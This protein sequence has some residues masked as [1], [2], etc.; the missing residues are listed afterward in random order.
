MAMRRSGQSGKSGAKA[1]KAS[2]SVLAGNS[3]GKSRV[4]MVKVSRDARSKRHTVRELSVDIALEGD[5]EAIHTRGDNSRCL[6]TDTMKNTVYALGKD[7]SIDTIESFATH[8]ARHFVDRNPQVS[9]A[10]VRISEVRWDRVAVRGREHPHCFI[11]GS[12]ERQTCTLTLARTGMTLTSG[13]EGLV[14]LKSTDSAFT[15]YIHD[16]YTTL[17]EADD[18]ILA[19]SVTAHWLYGNPRSAR[20]DPARCRDSIRLAMIEA[21]AGHKSESV[22]HTLH[23]MGGAALRA[24]RAID[25][26]RI[27]MPNK[28]CLLVNLAPFG[29]E[30]NNEVFLPIDEPHGLIEAAIEREPSAS[31]DR[32]GS[33]TLSAR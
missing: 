16:E 32:K 2:G 27:S 15:G 33:E 29:L 5:F 13:L 14:I 23:A 9:A 30:N 8:L 3:Y 20:L 24:C 6:P 31:R 18:R 28:H 11:K 25:T 19:T 17:P 26:I 10:R 4:R 7:H 12:E 21:F 1:R 22:Q